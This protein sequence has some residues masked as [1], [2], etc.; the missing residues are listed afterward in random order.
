MADGGT[1][2]RQPTYRVEIADANQTASAAVWKAQA[3]FADKRE[4]VAQANR[5]LDGGEAQVRVLRTASTAAPEAVVWTPA[6]EIPFSDLPVAD[7]TPP[8][9]ENGDILFS[10]L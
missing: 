1:M 3:E 6:D 4:A 5:L 9:D 2:N 8:A 10:R 7:Y